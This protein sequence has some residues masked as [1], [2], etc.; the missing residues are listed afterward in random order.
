MKKTEIVYQRGGG[1]LVYFWGFLRD[2]FGQVLKHF[3]DNDKCVV[4]EQ[5]YDCIEM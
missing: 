4:L 3:M 2:I 1:G 5:M